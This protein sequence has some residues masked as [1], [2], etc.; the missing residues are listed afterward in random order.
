MMNMRMVSGKNKNYLWAVMCKRLKGKFKISIGGRLCFFINYLY[1]TIE[2][3]ACIIIKQ[4]ILWLLGPQTMFD[5]LYKRYL[6]I[7]DEGHL[8]FKIVSK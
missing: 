5:W 4:V 8:E 1:A 6:G 3:L 7:K 2:M